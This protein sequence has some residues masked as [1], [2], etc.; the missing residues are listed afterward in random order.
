MGQ[1]MFYFLIFPF[2]RWRMLFFVWAGMISFA[3]VYVGVHYPGDIIA[4]MMLGGLIGWLTYK[5]YHLISIS[6]PLRKSKLV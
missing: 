6:L 2:F 1:A 3:Q 5:A 4:G